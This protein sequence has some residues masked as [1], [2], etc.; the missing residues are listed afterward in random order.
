[1]EACGEW[2][3]AISRNVHGFGNPKNFA[4]PMKVLIRPL[5]RKLYGAIAIEERQ[6]A[7]CDIETT[8][9]FQTQ[10]GFILCEHEVLTD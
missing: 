9:F 1:M 5:G 10:E 4:S 2:I 6:A 7:G 3:P 8:Q